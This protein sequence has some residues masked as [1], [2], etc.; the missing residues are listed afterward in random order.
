MGENVGYGVDSEPQFGVVVRG[1]GAC[2]SRPKMIGEY[3]AVTKPLPKLL[4]D[5]KSFMGAAVQGDGSVVL[6]LDCDFVEHKKS[7]EW[8]QSSEFVVKQRGRLI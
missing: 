7:R 2:F 5:E 8:T 1:L 4:R 3:E 6:I